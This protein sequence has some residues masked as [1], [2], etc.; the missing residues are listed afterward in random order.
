[1]AMHR[2]CRSLNL[3]PP[4]FLR[5]GFATVGDKD[6]LRISQ[7]KNALTEAEASF[8]KEFVIPG[9]EADRGVERI[10]REARAKMHRV[11]RHQGDFS[12]LEERHILYGSHGTLAK[13]VRVESIYPSRIVGCFGNEGS[14]A[15]DLL[16]HVVKQER[17]TVCLECGQ[18]FQLSLPHGEKL[19][20]R[21]HHDHDHDH[22]HDHSHDQAHDHDHGHG[23]SAHH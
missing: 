18:V 20:S 3:L 22:G 8:D 17:P 7:E 6:N 12:T 23:K 2:L 5:R 19:H 14:H 15:H 11:P 10:E 1:M 21:H 13:P 4:S 16:W 9:P